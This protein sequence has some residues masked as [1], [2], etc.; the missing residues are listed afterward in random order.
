M[1]ALAIKSAA[2]SGPRM[3]LSAQASATGM[4][5][6]AAR[7]AAEDFE[8][9]FLG[10]MF[11]LAMKD[12]PVDEVF[13]GGAGERVFRELMVD[14]WAKSAARQGGAGIADAVMKTLIQAQGTNS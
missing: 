6:T 1:D 5:P 8:A 9:Q 12:T 2:A 10:H 14:E 7:K 11:Q 13:G 3:D 4:D